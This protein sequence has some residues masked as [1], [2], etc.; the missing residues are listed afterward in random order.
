MWGRLGH[1]PGVHLEVL[2]VLALLA[3]G[4]CASGSDS[5]ASPSPVPDVPP[6]S[7]LPPTP[8]PTPAPTVTTGMAPF[9][10]AVLDVAPRSCQ[11]ASVPLAEAGPYGEVIGKAPVWAGFYANLRPAS[12]VFA[13]PD[14]VRTSWGWRIKVL[15]VMK[16][17]QTAPVVIDGSDLRTGASLWFL[18]SD[19]E[20]GPSA[21]LDPANPGAPS[22]NPGWLNFPSYL[23]FPNAGCFTLAVDPAGPGWDMTF[24]FGR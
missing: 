22:A 10:A 23:Y 20:A 1:V 2:G 19:A 7:S 18:P 9:I 12:G 8:L 5:V 24:G 16:A 17:D 15:W 21:I 14:A 11:G 6:A 4:A 13:A 3:I